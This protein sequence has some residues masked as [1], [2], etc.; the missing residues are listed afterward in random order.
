MQLFV[1]FFIHS[2][3]TVKDSLLEVVAW[4]SLYLLVFGLYCDC[5]V[6]ITVFI[7]LSCS[8]LVAFKMRSL[9]NPFKTRR[10]KTDK[11]WNKLISLILLWK[12]KQ[13]CSTAPTSNFK[14]SQTIRLSGKKNRKEKPFMTARVWFPF[15][16]PLLDRPHYAIVPPLICHSNRSFC[17]IVIL[18]SV[19]GWL[20]GFLPVGLMSSLPFRNRMKVSKTGTET[21][22]EA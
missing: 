16:Y 7:A 21:E 4:V 6:K 8:I 17:Q 18:L 13:I 1:V 5:K 15:K 3:K 14:R 11:R 19:A 22:R 12:K 2:I 10:R 20:N 9:W